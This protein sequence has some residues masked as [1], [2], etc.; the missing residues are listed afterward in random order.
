MR[1][2]SG[3]E[4]VAGPSQR[5]PVFPRPHAVISTH[6]VLPADPSPIKQGHRPAPIRPAGNYTGHHGISSLFA[7]DLLGVMGLAP[8]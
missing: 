8:L 2:S 7:S 5:T 6:P 4:A 1:V 3:Q